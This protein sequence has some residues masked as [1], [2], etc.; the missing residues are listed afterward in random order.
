MGGHDGP[1]VRKS[2]EVYDPA[3]NSWRQVADMNMCRRNAGNADPRP[4]SRHPRGRDVLTEGC[5]FNLGSVLCFQV[6]VPWTT[7][8]T[9]WEETMAAATWPPWSSTIQTR[10]SGRYCRPA[11][12]QG[13]VMQVC[14]RR[15]NTQ[16]AENLTWHFASKLIQEVTFEKGSGSSLVECLHQ[17]VRV[18][19]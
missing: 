10:T 5:A 15:V 6:C 16:G 14:R 2:C 7:Y 19:S 13:G 1:L 4:S 11:W 17:H 8:C 9:W 12:A 3:S 18:T